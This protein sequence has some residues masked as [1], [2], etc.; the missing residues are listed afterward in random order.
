MRAY[1]PNQF[2]PAH[3]FPAM[4]FNDAEPGPVRVPRTFNT[5]RIPVY[6][7][8]E[9]DD[10]PVVFQD[11]F[12]LDAELRVDPTFQPGPPSDTPVKFDCVLNVPF[13]DSE[14]T[15]RVTQTLSGF[16]DNFYEPDNF[17][18]TEVKTSLWNHLYEVG[19]LPEK[20][21]KVAE[22]RRVRIS[23]RKMENPVTRLK[24][25]Q[26]KYNSV[27]RAVVKHLSSKPVISYMC[28]R[29]YEEVFKMSKDTGV[30][31]TARFMFDLLDM[32]SMNKTRKNSDGSY[33]AD[34]DSH[35]AE[36]ETDK[37]WSDLSSDEESSR[38]GSKRP[39][40]VKTSRTLKIHHLIFKASK[41]LAS[42]MGYPTGRNYFYLSL[43][44]H[45]K[46]SFDATR[47]NFKAEVM[48]RISNKYAVRVTQY[49]QAFSEDIMEMFDYK[50]YKHSGTT[51]D[52]VEIKVVGNGVP[53]VVKVVDPLTDNIAVSD[54]VSLTP[55]K[56]VYF[57]KLIDRLKNRW[58]D[59]GKSPAYSLLEGVDNSYR[60]LHGLFY[61]GY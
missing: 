33:Y 7:T 18:V 6:K 20:L 27:E 38:V 53:Q 15:L 16:Y 55:D 22:D 30:P 4:P 21:I 47:G 48:L 29:D 59:Y 17:K 5:Y 61:Y 46:L 19:T 28:N 32:K 56:A 23:G 52:L 37:E 40:D 58:V 36:H 51:A 49:L 8:V 3:A 13:G 43:D 39:R 54:E 41:Y 14:H 45:G 60:M 50:T 42:K 34:Y 2:P 9:F 57:H 10:I 31:E 35:D 44:S 24:V 25:L 1:K 12:M 11:N 26:Q